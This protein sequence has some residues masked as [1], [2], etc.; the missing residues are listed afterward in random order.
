MNIR[1]RHVEVADSFKTAVRQV[2]VEYDADDRPLRFEPENYAPAH[3]H[4][5]ERA[6]GS[7][8][9]IHHDEFSRLEELLVLPDPD[10]DEIGDPDEGED[11]GAVYIKCD[12][13]KVRDNAT[14]EIFVS[15]AAL[16]RIDAASS[17]TTERL[18]TL[19]G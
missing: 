9:Y 11:S 6:D 8:V 12:P 14:Y 1:H 18:H 7:R 13:R 2:P 16:A 19:T 15:K 3:V 10:L 5:I 17:R 4:I